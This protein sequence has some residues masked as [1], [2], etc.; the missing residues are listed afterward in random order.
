MA[1]TGACAELAVV[2]ARDRMNASCLP[3]TIIINAHDM[4]PTMT[5]RPQRP[6][7]SAHTQAFAERR[8]ACYQWR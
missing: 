5:A 8:H 1:R 3:S 4:A 2:R 7:L 6:I